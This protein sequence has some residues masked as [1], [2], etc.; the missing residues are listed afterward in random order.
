[1]GAYLPAGI[2]FLG[3]ITMSKTKQDFELIEFKPKEASREQW[4]REH[5]YRRKRIA[6]KDRS[7]EL[8]PD[9]DIEK[10]WKQD[11]PFGSRKSFRVEEGGEVIGAFSTYIELPHAPGYESNKH[12]L[13]VDFGVLSD[14]RRKGIGTAFLRKTLQLMEEHDKQ[15][16]TFGTEEEAGHAFLKAIGAEGKSEGAEN[17]LSLNEVDWDLVDRW[18]K[19]GTDRNPQTTLEFYENRIPINRMAEFAPVFSELFNTMPFDD[20]D[21][22]D[23][24]MTPETW[25]EWYVHLD[26][27]KGAHHTYLT[28]EADGAV[29][30]MTD[31]TWVPQMPNR[32]GQNFTGVHPDHQGRGLGKWLK[33]VM[34]QYIRERYPDVEFVS[35]GNANSNAPML[36]INQKLGFKTHKG[37][38]TYQMT[39]EDLAKYLASVS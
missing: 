1:M 13:G 27:M 38:T 20:L 2:Q 26:N 11:T 6:E 4:D 23:I 18:A 31:V 22:G 39:R 29:S 3:E 17:R 34:L 33:A 30:G 15:V 16:V 36:A 9:E 37:G 24:V 5:V 12:L 32:V 19:D 35:T 28:R 7:D 25:K 21:H 8:F 10:M 14:H